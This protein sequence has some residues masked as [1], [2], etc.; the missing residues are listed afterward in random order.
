MMHVCNPSTHK[1][2][3]GGSHV[4]SLG[5]ILRLCRRKEGGR[6]EGGRREGGREGGGR[7]GGREE[8]KERRKQASKGTS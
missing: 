5:Y 8:R 4:C 7:E 2:E 1:A 3:A 6:E